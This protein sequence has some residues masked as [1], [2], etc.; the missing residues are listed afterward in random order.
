MNQHYLEYCKKQ[1]Q[2]YLDKA[3]SRHSKS[4]WKNFPNVIKYKL[5]GK[6]YSKYWIYMCTFI[7]K[8]DIV[9]EFDIWP[10]KSIPQSKMKYYLSFYASQNF[11]MTYLFKTGIKSFINPRSLLDILSPQTYTYYDYMDVWNNI[12]Y[13]RPYQHSWPFWFKK[14]NMS[15][16]GQNLMFLWLKKE[17]LTNG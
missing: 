11:K 5:C 9:L 4:P 6:L 14:I 13:L 10:K 15:I 8:L 12:L 17:K 2:D 16:G 3:L 7:Q 1:I